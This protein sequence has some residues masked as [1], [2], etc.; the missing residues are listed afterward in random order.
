MLPLVR[1]EAGKALELF[2]SQPMAHA[3]LGVIA[4][5]HEYDWKAAV[6]RPCFHKR[7]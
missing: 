2:P 4:A 5:L 3:L 7:F 1:A 6:R